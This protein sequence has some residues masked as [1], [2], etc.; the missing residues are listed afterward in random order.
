MT[1]VAQERGQVAWE[2]FLGDDNVFYL[3]CSGGDTGRHLPKL[4]DYMLEMDTDYYV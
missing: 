2:N 4:I 3:N 1:V